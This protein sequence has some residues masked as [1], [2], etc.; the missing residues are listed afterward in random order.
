MVGAYACIGSRKT[1][2][3]AAQKLYTIASVF[4]KERWT[5]TSGHSGPADMAGEA[6]HVDLNAPVEIYLPWEGFNGAHYGKRIG[7]VEFPFMAYQL[8]PVAT[9]MAMQHHPNWHALTP[10]GRAMMIRNGFQILRRDLA[11]PV[12]FVLCNTPGGGGTGG[13]GQALRIAAT[14]GVPVFDIGKNRYQDVDGDTMAALIM[15]HLE[16]N[17][18]RG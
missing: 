5:V 11:T 17:P 14:Y 1:S 6:S 18:K 10:G 8:L 12:D 2:L 3:S 4:A 7:E 15:E 16:R 9:T 13:T